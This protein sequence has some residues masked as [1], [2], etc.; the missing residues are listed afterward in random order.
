MN[1]GL[2]T[3]VPPKCRVLVALLSALVIGLT[4]H[5]NVVAQRAGT[6]EEVLT[7]QSVIGMA[8]AKINKDLLL[9]KV[10]T[11]RNS[12]DVTVNGII[13]LHQSKVHQD[14]IRSMI[15]LAADAKLG[16]PPT[17]TPE[18]LENQSVVTMVG[19]KLP[20]AIVLAKIQN[21]KAAFDVSANGLVSLTQAKVPADVIKAMVVKSGSDDK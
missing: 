2:Q 12:F 11:T 1:Q 14:V 19:A 9:A 17:K 7:N 21:T 3:G 13:N 20:K 6:A 18:V 10:N 5:G 16:Q 4:I 8:A 15:T